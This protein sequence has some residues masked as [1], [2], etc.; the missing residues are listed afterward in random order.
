MKAKIL[1]I[2]DTENV[3]ENIAEILEAEN[4][5]PHTA[6]NGEI[7]VEMARKIQPDLILCD[8]MMPGMD[9]YEVIRKL[10]E[11]EI[12]ATTPFIFLTAKS[13][14]EN[15]REGM[16]LG[17]DDYI[18]KP[19]TIEQLLDAVNTRLE[20]IGAMKKKADEAVK[21]LTNRI[22]LPFASELQD[23]M[24]AIVGF[25]EL[26]AT[27]YPNMEKQEIVD[28]VNMILKA[29][30]KLRKTVSKT[31]V[32]YRLEALSNK[33]EELKTL[34]DSATQG[35]YEVVEQTAQSV[36]KEAKR[37]SDLR[38][39]LVDAEVR[40]PRDL[41][42]MAVSELVE[43]A[44]KFSTRKT[45]VK[46]VATTDDSAYRL[47]IE[48]EGIGMSDEQ[49]LKAGAFVDYEQREGSE[50]GLGLG[51]HNAKRVIEL[52]DGTLKINSAPNQGTIIKIS[53]PLI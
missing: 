32:F 19:F 47:S 4:F 28:F 16:L 42:E 11:N 41:L 34:K 52:F 12:T 30:I 40:I 6:E 48:D 17:A 29:G 35:V 14:V 5:E 44:F 1:I 18:P 21:N 27:G 39:A 53:L 43:N 50:S 13:A 2:E 8:I 51:L 10:R 3:R 22:G 37:E 36:A 25:S 15:I 7:G 9:G 24:K 45:D 20:R 46:L 31:L 38:L 33:S 49:I 26:I 23:P